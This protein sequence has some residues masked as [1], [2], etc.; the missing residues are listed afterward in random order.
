VRRLIPAQRAGQ[1]VFD[2][3]LG[4]AAVLIAELNA[5]AGGAPARR[6]LGRH[7]DPAAR[8]REFLFLAH[9]VQQHEHFIAQT[10]VAVR[11]YEQSAVLHEGH[12]GEVQRALIL[13]GKRQQ[14][15]FVTWTSQFLPFPRLAS[16]RQ[17]G[18]TAEQQ[19]FQGQLLIH[20]G[21][22]QTPELAGGIQQLEQGSYLGLK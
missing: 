1:I 6:A 13:D 8:A 17:G 3:L 10:V 15:G 16:L 12:V 4:V 11:R 9:Q 5:D 18:S 7:P 19:S 14:T 22:C 2:F 20:T 21:R